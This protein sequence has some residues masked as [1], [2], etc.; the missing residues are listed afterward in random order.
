MELQDGVVV[1]ECWPSRTLQLPPLVFYDEASNMKPVL[2]LTS[3]A[4]ASRMFSARLS[5]KLA[6]QYMALPA[7]PGI[8]G[9]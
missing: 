2:Q 1:C 8:F 3:T 5:L 6:G 9:P 7:G 4:A